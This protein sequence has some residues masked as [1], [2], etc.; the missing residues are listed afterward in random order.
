MS[1]KKK[2]K[3]VKSALFGVPRP[4]VTIYETAQNRFMVVTR[5]AKVNAEEEVH[6]T[7]DDAVRFGRQ[8]LQEAV[9]DPYL[10]GYKPFMEKRKSKRIDVLA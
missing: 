7:R 6:G 8:K 4:S 1:L 3:A 9:V 5:A 2:F 10:D